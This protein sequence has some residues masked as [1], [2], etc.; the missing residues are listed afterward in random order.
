MAP[1]SFLSYLIA[2]F[3]PL[4]S[5]GQSTE[6][7]MVC[8]DT[9]V[10]IFDIAQSKDTIPHIIWQWKADEAVDL[11]ELYRTQ[12]FRTID[13]CKSVNNGS[14]ILITSSSSGVALID[15]S[16]KKVLFYAQ[17]GNAHS[18]ELLPNDRIVVAGST[19]A[20]GNRLE[21]FEI[22]QS[23]TP[24]FRDSLYSGHGA[25]WDDQKQLLYALGFDELRAYQL[26]NWASD[27]PSLKRVS[28]WKI[29]GEGGHDLVS[30]PNAPN[31]LILSEHHSV[32]LFD[33]T[34]EKFE[35]FPPLAN[36][37]DIK[38]ISLHPKSGRLAYI[39]AET[40]WWSNRVYLTN[41]D[42][43]FSFPTIRL[44]KTRWMNE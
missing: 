9:Q 5:Y 19:N 43:W 33:K 10:I 11:P 26:E 1:K 13:E 18:V 30:M 17:V 35:P 42:Q 44:Y 39:Q 31:K 2:F 23:E 15:K 8:G 21:L 28:T 37:E 20:K 14:Q 4:F 6:H 12:Y 25:V 16:T 40:S 24:L 38:G 36:R 32:W 3:I 22:N 29:P 27:R 41:P 34:T 7:L